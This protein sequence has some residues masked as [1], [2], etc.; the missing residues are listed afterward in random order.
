MSQLWLEESSE[1]EGFR[2]AKYTQIKAK[3]SIWHL[4]GIIFILL[5]R[6]WWVLL[7]KHKYI[8][9][10]STYLDEECMIHRKGNW[11]LRRGRWKPLDLRTRN[12]ITIGSSAGYCQKLIGSFSVKWLGPRT[13]S[14][15]GLLPFHRF[16]LQKVC[17]AS[18]IPR[19]PYLYWQENTLQNCCEIPVISRTYVPVCKHI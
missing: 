11:G 3:I 6:S 17:S 16:K 12:T 10:I 1:V 4:G 5:R 14:E 19:N 15:L 13:K 7:V 9:P 18:S 2:G 8:K